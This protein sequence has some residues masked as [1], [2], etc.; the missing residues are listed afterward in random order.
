MLLITLKIIGKVKMK[1]EEEVRHFI[2]Q[3]HEQHFTIKGYRD[4]QLCYA[5]LKLAENCLL[6]VLDEKEMNANKI[7]TYK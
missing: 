7:I 4:T 1:T 6:W 2:T 3:I 5:I